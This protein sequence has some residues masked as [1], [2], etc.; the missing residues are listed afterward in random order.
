MSSIWCDGSTPG[1]VRVIDGDAALFDGLQ[2]CLIGGHTQGLQVVRI[3]TQRGWV[4]LASDAVHY[5]ENFDE[6]NPFPAILDL[7]QMLD[8]YDRLADL[9]ETTD[10]IIPGHDPLVFERYRDGVS[11]DGLV[12]LHQFTPLREHAWTSVFPKSSTSFAARSSRSPVSALLLARSP[13]PTPPTT[14]GTSPRRW[15]RWDCSA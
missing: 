5:Y 4:V 8:G 10:H 2:V 3:R 1:S 9:A 13:A 6:R 12:A 11:P 7:G 14:P 15:R